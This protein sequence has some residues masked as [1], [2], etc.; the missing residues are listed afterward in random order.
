MPKLLRKPSCSIQEVASKDMAK[1][2][3]RR[4]EDTLMR[5]GL[6]GTE[7]QFLLFDMTIRA[8]LYSPSISGIT[9]DKVDGEQRVGRHE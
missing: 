7:S 8:C 9:L 2:T 4:Q 3:M 6:G 1:P 5:T